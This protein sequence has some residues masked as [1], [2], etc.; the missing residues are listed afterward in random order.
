MV[1][2]GA[3]P[4]ALRL[5]SSYFAALAVITHNK[6]TYL[7]LCSNLLETLLPREFL[8]YSRASK[9][10]IT[11]LS[12]CLSLKVTYDYW[13]HKQALGHTYYESL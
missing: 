4:W 8:V 12:G 1:F 10:D 9:Q 2:E 3:G 11:L 6:C 7:T 5:Q 13:I